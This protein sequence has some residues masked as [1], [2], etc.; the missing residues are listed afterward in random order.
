MGKMKKGKRMVLKRTEES[1]G[2]TYNQVDLYLDGKK[3]LSKGYLWG[4]DKVFNFDGII[5]VEKIPELYNMRVS[6]IPDF[7]NFM[8]YIRKRS[9]DIISFV[10]FTKKDNTLYFSYHLS[11]N[12]KNKNFKC[13]AYTLCHR[14]MVE[15]DK[16][17]F[18][19]SE[20]FAEFNSEDVTTYANK[21]YTNPSLILGDLIKADVKI[22][23]AVIKK[24]NK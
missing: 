2:K 3:I 12:Q 5:E 8:L 15:L 6:D 1:K 9:D 19:E 10:D 17:A 22:I 14:V 20:L 11:F 4:S 21:T 16:A 24:V 18:I 23:D 13:K 7:I